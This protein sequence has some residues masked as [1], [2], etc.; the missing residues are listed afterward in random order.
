[1]V[2]GGRRAVTTR[3]WRCRCPRPWRGRGQGAE[4]AAAEDEDDTSDGASGSRWR[5]TSIT[6]AMAAAAVRTKGARPAAQRQ[7]FSLN[8]DLTRWMRDFAGAG[9]PE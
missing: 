8:P 3:A 7:N 6:A 4:A 5:A 1:M 9:L 2:G